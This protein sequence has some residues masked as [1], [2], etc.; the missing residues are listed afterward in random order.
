M[1]EW[2]EY[3]KKILIKPD[4]ID[5]INLS[6]DRGKTTVS[7]PPIV[8]TSILILDKMIENQGDKQIIVFP[9]RQQ[10]ALIFALMRVI[11][12]IFVGKI[13]KEYNPESFVPGE[14][15]KLGDA[16]VEY[17]GI[18]EWQGKKCLM[19][20]MANL[21][22]Y[23][24]PIS[25]LPMF[26]KTN[27]RRPLSKHE[28][29]SAEKKR[30][31]SVRKFPE[32]DKV[33]ANTLLEYKT[34]MASSVYY[35]SSVASVKEQMLSL[36]ICSDK[37]SNLLLIGQVNYEGKITN[38]GTGQLSGVPAIVLAS[39]LYVVNSS[40]EQGNPVQSV[41]VDISNINIIL[42]QLDALDK[43][44][45][46]KIPVIFV[47]DT[48]NSFDF[49]ELVNRGFNI[50]RWNGDSLTSE[51]YDVAD[52][53]ADKRIGHCARQ[54]LQY[55]KVDGN[56]ISESAKILAKHR[57]TAQ[58]QSAPI[59]KMYDKLSNISFGVLR[60]TVPLGEFESNLAVRT[61][62]MCQS[63]LDAEKIYLSEEMF[64]DY[65]C[66]IQNYRK[67][68]TRGYTLYKHNVLCDI[69]YNNS[70]KKITIVIPEKTNK[71]RVED[72]WK[73]WINRQMLYIDLIVCSPTE[74]Y[75]SA[76][77]HSDITIIVGWL[78][79]AIMRKVIFSYNTESYIVLLYDCEERW[80]RYDTAKW[81]RS[82][83]YSNN[84]EIIQRSLSKEQL[85]ISVFS[86]E[87]EKK[88]DIEDMVEEDEL[89][90]INLILRENKYKQFIS[91]DSRKNGETV[92]AIPINFVGG[93]FAFYQRGHKLVSAS[94]IIMNSVDRIEIVVP[95]DLS[96]GDFVVVRE[97]ER[98]IVKDMADILL[99]NSNM[100][101]LREL[102]SKW[103]EVIKIELLFTTEEDFCHKMALAGCKKEA[104]TIKNWIDNEDMIAPREKEDLQCIADV[105]GSEVLKELLDDIFDAANTVRNAHIQAGRILSNQLKLKIVDVLKNYGDIDAFNFWEPIEIDVEDIGI[106]KILK[107]IDKGNVVRVDLSDTNRLIEE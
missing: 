22:K 78:R 30:I 67:V 19:L 56:E 92:E 1:I 3:V 28:K 11:H 39:D 100:G 86:Y 40:L 33:Q 69:L 54:K 13:E 75:S 29:F 104:A 88:T 10:T 50:W 53:I 103:R 61:L 94:Q 62:D 76:S 99:K 66:V 47:T 83:G 80:K 91:G 58:E 71:R 15:L 9:E 55:I 65:T 38:M 26:Q 101:N 42:K 17:L 48:A 24:A 46:R 97:S 16:I 7:I 74:Y 34:H 8:K 90:E 23:G 45:G 95:E 84:K 57:K 51:L 6:F 43:L 87:E 102:A 98:D 32:T 49:E 59:M 20:H 81:S 4:G 41:I 18:E 36:R 2:N 25:T 73:L 37:A 35:I 52:T 44:L 72:Y 79:R 27:T 77:N 89:E 85:K 63:I 60:E 106:V 68:Y 14:K 70:N 93:F 105:T 31:L 21:D 96:V 5:G 64:S 107:V 12:N 82:L